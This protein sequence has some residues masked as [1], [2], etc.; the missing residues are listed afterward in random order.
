M[1][2][3]KILEIDATSDTGVI[4][5]AYRAKLKV[6]RPDY[7]EDAFMALR[8]AYEE[9]LIYAENQSSQT[10]DYEDDY[11]FDDYDKSSEEYGSHNFDNNNENNYDNSYIK[12]NENNNLHDNTRF[13]ERINLKDY[14]KNNNLHKYIKFDENNNAYK[15]ADFNNF[16]NLDYN[17][18]IYTSK[19]EPAN[20]IEFKEWI[21]RFEAVYDDYNRRNR[22][23]EWKEL[24]NNDIPYQ[25]KYYEL[26]R[27]QIYEKIFLRYKSIYIAKEVRLFIDRF[28]SFSE[29]PL[30][31]AKIKDENERLEL[32][33]LN[34]KIK[35]CENI[36]FDK[37][38]SHEANGI[39]IDEFF[40]RFEQLVKNMPNLMNENKIDEVKNTVDELMQFELFY[41]P[42]ECLYIYLHFEEF[43]CEQ[44][45]DR[46]SKLQ[47]KTGNELKNVEN[48][49]KLENKFKVVENT[50]NSE[51]ELKETEETEK[52]EN[53]EFSDKI[54][55]EILKVQLS[56]HNG[57]M[58][59]AKRSLKE[60]YM[61]APLKN[62]FALYQMIQ[63]L[64]EVSMYYEA[65]MLIKQLTWLSPKDFMYEMAQNLYQKMESEYLAKI[66]EAKEIDDLEHIHMCRMYLRSNREEKA[67]EAINRVKDE[68]K[69][70]WEYEVAHLLCVFYEESGKV[71]SN[72]YVIGK[73][74]EPE[75][76]MEV[77]PAKKIFEILKKYPKEKLGN[78]ERLE[79]QELKGRY[80]FEQRR[81]DECDDLCNEL[82]EEYPA[83][84]PILMLR[85]YADYGKNTFGHNNRFTEYM[86]FSYLI[87]VLPKRR[88]ARLI[89][90]QL[91]SF[92]NWHNKTLEVL[93]PI[94]NELPDHYNFYEIFAN[95][96]I[97]KKKVISGI[98]Q[99]FENSMSRELDIPPVNKY[100]LLDLRNIFT[101]A[102]YFAGDVYDKHEREEKYIFFESLKDSGYNHPELY[103]EMSY[104]YEAME[105]D[106]KAAKIEKLKLEQATTE[107]EKKQIYER[108]ANIY[109]SDLEN[110]KE[111]E[112][113][114][115]DKIKCL[116]M[117]QAAY[118]CGE[119]ELAIYYMEMADRLVKGSI[120][121]YQKLGMSY[122]ALGNNEKALEAYW[123][124]IIKYSI[125][126]D[127]I[128][129]ATNSY[130]KIANIYMNQKKW[131]DAFEVLELM[132][133]YT[134]NEKCLAR[135]Y[136]LLGHLYSSIN[137]NGKYTENKLKAWE[138]AIE[139][140]YDIPALYHDVAKLYV[141]KREYD[142]ALKTI[143]IA[144]SLVG[145][146]GDYYYG[147][148]DE[149]ESNFYLYKYFIY[150]DEM[151]DLDNAMEVLELM[152][153]NT[154]FEKF[155]KLYYYYVGFTYLRKGKE[156]M[157]KVTEYWMEA[158]KHECIFGQ[159]YGYLADMFIARKE[160]DKAI[161]ILKLATI[162][163]KDY[164]D[165]YKNNNIF[166]KLYYMYMQLG[167][168]EEAF[169]I[170]FQ[171]AE[172]TSS[173]LLKRESLDAIASSA[174]CIFDFETSF[175][176]FSKYYKALEDDGV[177]I[178]KSKLCNFYISAY[179][180]ALPKAKDLALELAFYE[181]ETDG[182]Y[183]IRALRSDYVA[184][185]TVDIELAKKIEEELCK[186]IGKE[187]PENLYAW[188]VEVNTVLG[189]KEK[190]K[191]YKKE[192]SKFSNTDEEGDCS[193]AWCYG[194]KGDYKKAYEI[195]DSKERCKNLLSGGVLFAEYCFFKKMA[196]K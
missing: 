140:H 151:K 112:P 68:T 131:E 7:D 153:R 60:L 29:T 76:I 98:R 171:I 166:L 150:C 133:T 19:K 45:K 59:I 159:P 9:A 186:L 85:S 191:E 122:E 167:R 77:L 141:N 101:Y 74:W 83:S 109:S 105:R 108:L 89:V 132:H 10:F 176:Y 61:K 91:F 41:L 170:S 165:Y 97:D 70:Q 103:M 179:I 11:D 31:R 177:K 35:L 169:K 56:I 115:D 137:V 147:T 48:T 106:D 90:A 158:V 27:K 178:L 88:E 148:S 194:Y 187:A 100:R 87:K 157:L 107:R 124:G 121:L 5:K 79:W 4:K 6:T 12:F 190:V 8:S 175:E 155:Q 172:H 110:L 21:K 58:E 146:S 156:Y 37:L 40:N 134:R 69:Y 67:I 149:N 120:N 154:R 53:T 102:C 65:Y 180:L 54:E 34:N 145:K 84:Y 75:P 36:E 182:Y 136:Y 24:L 33:E 142:K 111:Y 3:W 43:S 114:L 20:D 66:N 188:L 130:G 160:Y 22:L 46:I 123:R 47:E 78:I 113:Y 104:L 184:N 25:I 63:C 51:K 195:Y 81:Y 117:G 128:G 86:D 14:D 72:L 143:D 16:E 23:S 119:Y 127:S 92:S 196:E 1:D 99:I 73:T 116:C 93:E 96:E 174:I 42:L 80:L 28:F 95:N 129:G 189:N 181:E 30:I 185:L 17:E 94:K 125:S 163:A 139:L 44:N 13:D 152:K 15:F 71:P 135:C 32:N 126:G 52:I 64:I 138:K 49:K 192:L 38:N 39:V 173:D 18:D 183:L 118:T 168:F 55:L 50:K 144:I 2:I 26:C 62:Y 57:D 193:K 82:L 164:P 161:T 162:Y